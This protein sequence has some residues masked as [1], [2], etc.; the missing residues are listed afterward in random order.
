ML[1]Q[2][3]LQTEAHDRRA[4]QHRA[5]DVI[6]LARRPVQQRLAIAVRRGIGHVQQFAPGEQQADGQVHQEEQNQERLGAPQQ[7]RRVRTQA[8]GETDAE[9]ADEA[10]QVEQAPGLEPGDGENAGVEQARNN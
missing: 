7:L 1:D 4:E 5:V 10:D 3:K 2:R 8:P 9:G 6:A